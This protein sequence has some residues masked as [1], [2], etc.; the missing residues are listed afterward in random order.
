MKIL[1]ITKSHDFMV[2]RGASIISA[3]AR[4]K[5]HETYL[6]NMN[7]EDPLE[8]IASLKPEMIAYSSLSGEAKH[9]IKLNRVIKESFP[10]LFT[11]MGG[12]HPTFYHDL[13]K[14]STLDAICIGEGEGAFADVLDRLSAGQSVEG[15]ANILT[16]NGDG[17]FIRDAVADLDSLPFPDYGL[18]YDNVPAMGRSPLKSIMVSRGCVFSC[19]Y[20]HNAQWNKIYRGKGKVFRR[21]SVEYVMEDINRI[22]WKWPL[23]CVKFYDDTFCYRV[24]DWLEAFCLQY[25]ERVNLPFF[26][27]TRYDLLTE[28]MVKILKYAGCRTI[29]MSIE[30][31][32]PET[33]IN[34]L[35]RGM[36]DEQILRA[37]LLCEKYGIYTFTN[38]ILAL[39]GSTI[40]DDIRSID[41]AIEAK[42]TWAEFSPFYPYPGTELGD[43]T[44]KMGLYKPDYEHMHTSYQNRSLLRCFNDREKTA[45]TN[46]TTLGP[47]AVVFPKLRNMIVNH[48]IYWRNN[49]VFILAYW[50]A[51]SLVLRRKIYYTKTSH[52]QSLCIYARSLKQELFRHTQEKEGD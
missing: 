48:L 35:R 6:C 51:K 31:G 14:T 11:I 19:S 4:G 24:D 15:I 50:L 44:I 23:S 37:S 28:D 7:S 36:S 21:H 25:K 43:Y 41:L 26:I 49:K 45:Q 1:F 16:R 33:R 12:H 42:S 18:F 38:A 22:R 20:C 9:Y 13:I 52:W 40:K 39:P 29:S 46:L 30:A 34:T 2:Q 32:N 3:V 27:L 17:V 8:R 5:A 10:N 47:V